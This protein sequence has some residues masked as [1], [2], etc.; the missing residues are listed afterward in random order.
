MAS[1]YLP[2]SLTHLFERNAE[3]TIYVGNIDPRVTDEILWELFVQ[4]GQ[5]TNINLPRDKITGE[6]QGFGFVEFK[7]EVESDYAIKVMHMIKLFGQPIKCNRASTDKKSLEVGANIY[8]GNLSDEVDERMLKDV[9]SAFGVVLSTKMTRNI[10][11]NESKNFGFVCFDNFESSDTAIKQ[12]DGQYLC[13]KPIKVTYA[14]KSD[15][16]KEKHGSVAERI[17]AANKPDVQEAGWM[18]NLVEDRAVKINSDLGS[19]QTAFGTYDN[20][21][22]SKIPGLN[23]PGMAPVTGMP[24]IPGM[25]NLPNMHLMPR[26]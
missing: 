9:F 13:G 12:M 20:P 19:Y 23:V 3:A 6:H 5:V 14:Y 4:I 25:P 22:Y 1:A 21:D 15:S 24:N 26:M 17:I 11:S 8:V 7:S 18:E 2:P 10:E 16:K